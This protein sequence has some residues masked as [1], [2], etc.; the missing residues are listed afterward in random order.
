MD[1]E[2][3]GKEIDKIDVT[4]SYRIIELFSKGLYSSPNKAFEELVCNSYD[5]GATE[6]AIYI[7]EDLALKP[8][9]WILDNGEGMNAD[10]LKEL[11]QVGKSKKRKNET[12]DSKL[13]KYNVQ[14]RKQIGK[15]GIG[16][17]AT[18]IITTKLTYLSKTAGHYYATTMD[19]SKLPPE[20]IVSTVGVNGQKFFLSERELTEEEARNIIQE[21]SPL[22]TKKISFPLFGSNSPSSWTFCLMTALSPGASKIQ[23]GQL[24]W[25]LRTALPLNPNFSLMLN[26]DKIESSKLQ[27]PISKEWIFGSQDDKVA[28]REKAKGKLDIRV[29]DSG[30][31]IDLPHLKNVRGYATLYRESI[32][33]GKSEDMGRSNG[34]FLK[35]RERLINLE[36]PLL[37]MA[38]LQHGAF[39]RTRIIVNADDLD[40]YLTSG[41]ES[42]QDGPHL[43]DLRS[44]LNSFFYSV[45]KPQWDIDTGPGQVAGLAFHKLLA[46]SGNLTRIP[47]SQVVKRVASDQHNDLILN[48]ISPTLAS[49][50]AFVQSIE[51]DLFD[52]KGIVKRIEQ[53]YLGPEEPVAILDYKEKMIKINVAHPFIASM[54]EE[55]SHSRSIEVIAITEILTEAQLIEAGYRQ[56]EVRAIMDKRDKTLRT[57]S[58]GE[59]LSATNLAIMLEDAV[60]YEK[61]LE[62]VLCEC[63]RSLGYEVQKI[64]GP[65]EPDGVAVACLGYRRQQDCKYK[66][67]LDAKSTLSAKVQTGNV[68]L[69][70][71]IIHQDDHD[72]DYVVIVGKDFDGSEVSSSLINKASRKLQITCMRA[73]D[74]SRLLFLASPKMLTLDD[75]KNMLDTCHTP[76]EVKKWIDELAKRPIIKDSLIKPFIDTIYKLQALDVEPAYLPAIRVHMQKDHPELNNLLSIP[77]L[78]GLAKSLVRLVP[79]YISFDGSIVAITQKPD[80]ILQE[81]HIQ[82]ES[83]TPAYHELYLNAFQKAVN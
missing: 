5:A 43:D 22:T 77:S 12:Y 61:P 35:V 63:F 56:D 4:I 36:D 26:G 57:L 2:N 32:A 62:T 27:T 31:V 52:D 82:I 18:Y 11:W 65:G 79:K 41:R 64:C 50:A 23:I 15:F 37:G 60:N 10:G 33:K 53:D 6:V 74:L 30:S 75:I 13:G 83:V 17:L 21:Y 71:A 34:I 51:N 14:N 67:C 70:A 8:F 68:H 45:I 38:P 46:G 16:K 54:Q 78:E 80:R 49:D 48:R 44:F 47:L 29:I 1:L 20:D 69:D 40:T 7:P 72:A 3:A 28:Q 42:I 19:Y 66:I 76:D 39:S 59:R 24:D 55:I 73:K 9:I 25:I 81:L 58:Y